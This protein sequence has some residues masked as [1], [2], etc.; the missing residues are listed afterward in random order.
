MK[1]RIGVIG[2][3]ID[4]HEKS[5]NQ[6]QEI[7]GHYSSLIIGRMGIP[8]RERGIAVISLIVE[9]NTDEIGALTGLLGNLEGVTVK[10]ALTAK[11][12]NS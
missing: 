3:V 6:V 7:L 2:I 1:K 12:Y 10:T 8:Y 11:E 9:G 4:S 5:G